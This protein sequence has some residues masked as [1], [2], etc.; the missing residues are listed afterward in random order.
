M[1]S[2]LPPGIIRRCTARRILKKKKEDTYVSSRQNPLRPEHLV[3]QF[4]KFHI[5]GFQKSPLL[6]RCTAYHFLTN[7]IP[8]LYQNTRRNILIV[9]CNKLLYA[10][11]VP[12]IW[13]M[14]SR[15]LH[16][17]YF[18]NLHRYAF[19]CFFTSLSSCHLQ[20]FISKHW[21]FMFFI[22]RKAG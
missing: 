15:I 11:H 12:F 13:I 9:P 5:H 2:W 21:T 20:H 14:C 1:S 7:T 22:Q 4:I 18:T 16:I 3:S 17:V 8:L 10:L 19:F 6:K